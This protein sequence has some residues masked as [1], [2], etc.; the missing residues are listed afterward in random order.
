MKKK[1]KSIFNNVEPIG[2]YTEVEGKPV[3][4]ESLKRKREFAEKMYP[5]VMKYIEE[6]E[7]KEKK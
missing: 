5:I 3:I 1:V 7:K 6:R 4:S 2:T